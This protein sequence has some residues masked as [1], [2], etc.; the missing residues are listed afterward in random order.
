MAALF[1]ASLSLF[2]TVNLILF[3]FT[4]CSDL[5]PAISFVGSAGGI[6]TIGAGPLE[7]GGGGGGALTL[8]MADTGVSEAGAEGIGG[9]GGGEAG[10]GPAEAAGGGGGGGGAAAAGAAAST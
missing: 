10:M 4:L 5:V 9:E 3:I 1:C 8:R 7:V 2:E 6:L